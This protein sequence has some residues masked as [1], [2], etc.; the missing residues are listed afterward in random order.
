MLLLS[1]VVSHGG[2]SMKGG[3]V[4][5]PKRPYIDIAFSRVGDRHPVF[6]GESKHGLWLVLRNN[7]IYP[8]RVRI[9]TTPNENPGRLVAHDVFS[10]AARF[11]TP[12]PPGSL[13]ANPALTQPLGYTVADVVN[14]QELLPSH[15][16]LFSLPLEHVSRNWSISVEVDLEIPRPKTG[17]QPRTFADFY[18][19]QLSPEAQHLSDQMLAGT[20]R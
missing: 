4:I 7:C 9:L 14:T 15:D 2:G 12:V 19:S 6:P 20:L 10:T 5:D 18:F 3:F 16:L 17:N 8:I 13:T 11:S 1:S